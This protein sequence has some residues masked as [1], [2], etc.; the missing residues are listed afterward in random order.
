MEKVLAS[1][2]TSYWPASKRS[3]S[4]MSSSSL[5]WKKRT[6][7]GWW[8]WGVGAWRGGSQRPCSRARAQ[9]PLEPPL[10]PPAPRARLVE[11]SSSHG[12]SGENARVR[13]KV[14]QMGSVRP[15]SW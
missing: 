12:F 15:T 14:F 6:C 1:M 11:N 7:A 8:G 9:P 4:E 2:L 13:P 3:R 10:E 5:T